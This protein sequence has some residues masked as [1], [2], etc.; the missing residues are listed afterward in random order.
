MVL[1]ST[2]SRT[3]GQFPVD[4]DP[5]QTTY[6]SGVDERPLA[7]QSLESGQLQQ[8]WPESQRLTC[9]A[10]IAGAVKHRSH[11]RHGTLVQMWVKGEAPFGLCLWVSARRPSTFSATALHMPLLAQ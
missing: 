6:C 2:N 4:S 5:L 7:G 11:R 9:H 1:S 8:G 10:S 3:A